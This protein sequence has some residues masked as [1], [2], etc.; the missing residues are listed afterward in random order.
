VKQLSITDASDPPQPPSSGSECWILVQQNDGCGG[1][2]FN[3]SWNSYREGFGN[4]S[5]NYWIGNKHLHQMTQLHGLQFAVFHNKNYTFD[6][7]V[8]WRACYSECVMMSN[9]VYRDGQLSFL[10]PD[11]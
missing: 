6:K 5:G 8:C 1:Q 9:H 10:Q 11:I 2:F 4:A 3:R 7:T